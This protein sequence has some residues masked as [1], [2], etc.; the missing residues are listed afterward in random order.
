MARKNNRVALYEI[1]RVFYQTGDSKHELPTEVNHLGLA[2]TGNIHEKDWQ[3]QAQKV[4]FFHLK[5]ILENLFDSLVLTD[6]IRY[7]KNGSY[8]RDASW[9][10]GNDLAR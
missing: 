3:T 5:G 8:Q 6:R 4:D 2:L 7:Q 9:S 10:Y 1:G